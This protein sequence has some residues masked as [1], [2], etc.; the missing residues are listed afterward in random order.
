MGKLRKLLETAQDI[1]MDEEEI[2]RLQKKLD[3][4]IKDAEKEPPLGHLLVRTQ[5][6]LERADKRVTQAKEALT[7]AHDEVVRKMEELEKLKAE[8]EEA[9]ARLAEIKKSLGAEW[10]ERAKPR[11]EKVNLIEGLLDQVLNE[12]HQTQ[13]ANI[14]EEAVQPPTLPPMQGTEGEKSTKKSRAE[15]P[16][17]VLV[18]PDMLRQLIQAVKELR[19]P[20]GTSSDDEPIFRARQHAR[21]S[22]WAAC[23]ADRRKSMQL[24]R[25]REVTFEGIGTKSPNVS[26]G[27]VSAE[28]PHVPKG[29]NDTNRDGVLDGAEELRSCGRSAGTL[30]PNPPTAD[31]GRAGGTV[32]CRKALFC[33][34]GEGTS[35]ADIKPVVRGRSVWSCS[36]PFYA[37]APWAPV[38]R[39][40]PLASR[41]QTR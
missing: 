34:D 35:A 31:G 11:V 8:K 36:Q 27:C 1:E 30:P 17:P 3:K 28:Q 10:Q 29:T 33:E 20:S 24:R 41:T 9:A 2:D 22:I 14:A 6:F 12:Q 32:A 37:S 38:A 26:R 18:D 39:L 23:Q 16:A 40:S 21:I 13:K 19:S 7:K 15:K 4:A 25:A 5:K